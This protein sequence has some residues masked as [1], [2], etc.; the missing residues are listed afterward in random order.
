MI[1]EVEL[2]FMVTFKKQIRIVVTGPESTGKTTLAKQL[3]EYYHGQYIQEYAREFIEKLPHPYT[4][5][6]VEDIAKVQ[7]E[8]FKETQNSPD[9]VFIFDTWLIITKVWF[10]W[11]FKKAPPWI[12]GQIRSFPMDLFLL[13]QPD[14]PWEADRVRENG[15]TNRIKLFEQYRK[16]LIYYGF[17]FVE[18]SGIGEE[19]LTNA[20][21]AIRKDCELS[22]TLG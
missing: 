4:Y 14:I 1:F 16:E 12:E 7:I 18:I 3:A 20:I 13:C 2:L 8:Q 9:R 21:A 17:K 6:D 11:V 22:E 19:R 5:E 15:G 10:D